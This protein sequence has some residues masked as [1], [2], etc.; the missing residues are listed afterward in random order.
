MADA[1]EDGRLIV[2]DAVGS[3]CSGASECADQLMT[4]YLV[5]LEAP[6]EETD[7]ADT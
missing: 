5:D 2:V 3:V 7:C 6:A 4:D 1:L